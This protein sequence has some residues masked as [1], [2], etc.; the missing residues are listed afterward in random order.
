M[1]LTSDN[2]KYPDRLRRIELVP[3]KIYVKGNDFSIFK[4]PAIAV[5]GSRKASYYG[6]QT[7]RKLVSQ[8]VKKGFVLVS[9]MARGID[10]VAHATALEAGGQTIAV[11]GSGIDV[12]YPPENKNLYLKIN[13][14]ISEFPPGTPPERKNFL[15]RNRIIAGLS[16]GLLVVEAAKRSGTLNTA[17]YAAEQGKEVFAVPGPINS[18]LSEGTAWLIKQGAKLVYS[19]EDVLEELKHDDIIAKKL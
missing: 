19:I 13:L 7:T 10:S 4:K 16:D 2:K 11:L 3:P 12:I 6:R 17:K 9:G 1:I 15:I 14:I 8:L 18:P 5:V